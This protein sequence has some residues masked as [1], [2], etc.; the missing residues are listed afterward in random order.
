MKELLYFSAPW[1]APCR[2]LGPI[3]DEVTTPMDDVFVTRVDVDG[4]LDVYLA[5]KHEVYSV[6][7]LLLMEG[8]EVQKRYIGAMERNALREW[9]TS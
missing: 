2:R 6:P 4:E 8:E 1:C 5:M 7:T 9:L 3:I